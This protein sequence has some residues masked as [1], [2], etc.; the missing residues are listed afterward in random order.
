MSVFYSI[1]LCLEH[2][3]A[4]N[5]LILNTNIF[6]D[7][8]NFIR[9]ITRQFSL[10]SLILRKIIIVYETLFK[11]EKIYCLMHMQKTVFLKSITVT[12]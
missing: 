8:I 3:C 2:V 5:H 4:F 9:K 6:V 12:Y 7:Y 11:I 10:A 1:K